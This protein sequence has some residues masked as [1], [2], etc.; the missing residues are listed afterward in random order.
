V[1]VGPR[2]PEA[3]GAVTTEPASVLTYKD[4]PLASRRAPAEQIEPTD[5]LLAGKVYRKVSNGWIGRRRIISSAEN[6]AIPASAS[7]LPRSW[8]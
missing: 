3:I 5:A 7:I 8:H 4:D 1:I 6:A 2:R